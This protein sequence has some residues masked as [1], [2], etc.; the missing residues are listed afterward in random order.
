[1]HRGWKIKERRDRAEQRKKARASR[2]DEEQIQILDQKYGPGQGATRER[3]RLLKRI[4]SRNK[5]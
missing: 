4:A 2:T 3:N 5:A 1:M